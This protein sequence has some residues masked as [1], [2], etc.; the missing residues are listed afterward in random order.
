MSP[1][2]NVAWP[3]AGVT[4]EST[5]TGGVNVQQTSHTVNLPSGFVSGDLVVV[6]FRCTGTGL[7]VPAGWTRITTIG[8]TSTALFYRVMDGTEGTTVTVASGN[9][10]AAYVAYRLSGV[11]TAAGTFIVATGDF[12]TLD[13]PSLSIPWAG[14]SLGVSWASCR[15]TDN[16]LTQPSPYADKI[17]GVTADGL[18]TTAAV[19][20]ASANRELATVSEDPATWTN[21][22]TINAPHSGVYAVKPA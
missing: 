17:V 5:V 22:G 10:Y 20:I 7:T 19:R 13:S 9:D 14:D 12:G 11:D 6:Q 2:V 21:T 8:T 3:A 1:F 4:I 15:R 18:A 16:T